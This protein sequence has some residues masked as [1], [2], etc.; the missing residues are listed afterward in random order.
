MKRRK[1]PKDKRTGVAKKYLS[2]V[3]GGRRTQLAGVIKQIARL[4]KQGKT[5]PASLI[6]RR[7]NLGKKKK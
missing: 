6:Q 4:Y 7:I 2:G 3:K 5:V 1:V